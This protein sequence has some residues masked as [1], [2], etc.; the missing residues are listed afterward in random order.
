[1]TGPTHP[2]P[3]SSAPR[4]SGRRRTNPL[5]PMAMVGAAV[6]LLGV[7]VLAGRLHHQSAPPAVSPSPTTTLL[8]TVKGNVLAKGARSPCLGGPNGIHQGATVNVADPL[9]AILGTSSLGPGAP[10]NAGGCTWSYTVQ[11]PIVTGYQIQVGGL[12]LASVTRDALARQ[13]WNFY[14]ND[15]TDSAKLTNI[16][17]GV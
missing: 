12:P 7:G 5:L 14:E 9:G 1:M 2:A 3:P 8:V 4:R 17:S 13:A 16:E 10:A 6:A 11:L 15:T